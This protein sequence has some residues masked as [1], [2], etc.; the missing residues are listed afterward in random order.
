M[1]D[2]LLKMAQEENE[3]QD[4]DFLPE[5]NADTYWEKIKDKAEFNIHT[6]NGEYAG[7]VAFYCNNEDLK[8]SYITLIMVSPKFRGKKIGSGLIDYVLAISRLRGFSRCSLEV[9]KTNKNAIN[10]YE[11]KGFSVFQ[12]LENSFIMKTNLY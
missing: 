12:E 6:I 8:E 10:I 11:S 1:F 2:N 9:K 7:F 5:S 4:N 3:R